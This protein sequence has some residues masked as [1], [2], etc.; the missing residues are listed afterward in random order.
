VTIGDAPP[1]EFCKS[2]D[3]YPAPARETP[4]ITFCASSINCLRMSRSVCSCIIGFETTLVEM[5][6][7]LRGIIAQSIKNPS[8]QM[9]FTNW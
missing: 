4:P 6:A 8:T 5:L 2:A 7:T 3:Q 9:L 1:Q